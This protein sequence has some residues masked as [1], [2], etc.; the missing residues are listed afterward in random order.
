MI[1]YLFVIFSVL[2]F[3][4]VMFVFRPAMKDLNRCAE[5][6]KIE[7]QNA[8]ELAKKESWGKEKMCLDAQKSYL[9]LNSCILEA[10]ESGIFTSFIFKYSPLKLAFKGGADKHYEICPQYPV[11]PIE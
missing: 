7:A 3:G 5:E 4:F 2:I 9:N 1:K 11:A 6:Y 8:L 10:K